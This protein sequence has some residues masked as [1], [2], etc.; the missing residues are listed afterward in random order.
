ME[1]IFASIDHNFQFS[2]MDY[3]DDESGAVVVYFYGCN[4]NC[5][6]C[7][8]DPL[9]VWREDSVISLEYFILIL[10]NYCERCNTTK[11]VL[12]GGDPLYKKNI[13]F[14][15]QLLFETQF[16]FDVCIYTG[17]SVD[18]VIENN[19]YGFKYLKCGKYVEDLKQESKK[20]NEGFWL[21]STNQEFYDKNYKQISEKG[22]LRFDNE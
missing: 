2:F 10:K 7:H 16:I 4:N 5:D 3:P 14:T 8:N 13:E 17:Y 1:N 6:G 19:V 12:L 15:K 22:F 9:S 18:F 20:T 21:A 11:V